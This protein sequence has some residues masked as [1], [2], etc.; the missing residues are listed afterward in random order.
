ML[1]SE[2]SFCHFRRDCGEQIINAGIALNVREIR[3]NKE[4]RFL[5]FVLGT[6]EVID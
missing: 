6:T 5:R 4:I 1:Y 2:I 3:E